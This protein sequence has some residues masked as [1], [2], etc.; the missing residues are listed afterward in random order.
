MEARRI[1]RR[2]EGGLNVRSRP[3]SGGGAGLIYDIFT[4]QGEP[5][6]PPRDGLRLPPQDRP[7]LPAGEG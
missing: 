1:S 6:L 5:R 3:G 2:R 7:R 4:D